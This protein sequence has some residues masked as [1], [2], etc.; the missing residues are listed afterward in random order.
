MIDHAGWHSLA[1][2]LGVSLR[3]PE[4]VCQLSVLP[5]LARVSLP[6]LDE[7]NRRD[8]SEIILNGLI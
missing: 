6:V 1:P 7:I 5:P 4:Q 3:V 8:V 2:K